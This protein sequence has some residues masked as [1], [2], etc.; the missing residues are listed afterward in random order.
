MNLNITIKIKGIFI[1]VSLNLSSRAGGQSVQSAGDV[2]SKT[3]HKAGEDGDLRDCL[4]QDV[5]G[6]LS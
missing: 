2:N 5:S 1:I 6:R 3:M 4:L